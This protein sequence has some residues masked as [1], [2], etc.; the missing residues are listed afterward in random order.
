MQREHRQDQGERKHGT[1]QQW[2]DG[3]VAGDQG[4][5]VS[6]EMQLVECLEPDQ[7]EGSAV[8]FRISH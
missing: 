6:L 1:P 2:E 5:R 8:I 3:R 7:E 4:W